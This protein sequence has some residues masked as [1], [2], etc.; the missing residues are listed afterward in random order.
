MLHMLPQADLSDLP[1]TRE[2]SQRFLVHAQPYEPGR[3]LTISDVVVPG[4]EGSS[5][6]RVRVFVPAER[7]GPLPGLLYLRGSAFVLG[8]LE[9]VESPARRVADQVDVAVVAVDYRVAP[10]HPYPAA[11]DDSFAALTWASS[12]QAAEYGIDPSRIAVL[13][14]SAGGGLAAA[15]SMLTRD[16]NGPPIIAQF[17]DAPTIDDRCDTPSMKEFTDTPMWRSPDSPIAWEHYLGEIARGGD[18]VPFY[19]A[20]ARASVDDLVGLPPAWIAAYQLDPT[21]DEALEFAGRL[22][23]AGVPTELHHYAGA[24]HMAH[25]IPGTSIGARILSDKLAAI[26]RML[27]STP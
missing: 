9:S 10:E 16:R 25:T 23:R 12:P 24:F 5:D 21:R 27:A 26:R 6:V 1:G 2:L 11:L 14:D 4:A 15:L 8:S 18:D 3:E 22:V 7:T 13:G 19:A 17:L 20:P